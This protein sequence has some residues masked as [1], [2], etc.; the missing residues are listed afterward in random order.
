MT[1]AVQR[2]ERG[3]GFVLDGEIDISACLSVWGAAQLP[4]PLC[5][6]LS[7][8]AGGRL[9]RLR[10]ASIGLSTLPNQVPHTP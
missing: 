1:E 8:G 9:S 7:L 2:M 5:S 10:L 3:G 4:S 6:L